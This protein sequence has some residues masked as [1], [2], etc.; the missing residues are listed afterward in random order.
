MKKASWLLALSAVVLAIVLALAPM[1]TASAQG[2]CT[3][4]HNS[5]MTRLAGQWVCA[6]TGVACTECSTPSGDCYYDSSADA[7]GCNIFEEHRW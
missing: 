1:P 7:S 3:T 5:S 2:G 4:Y 6:Y